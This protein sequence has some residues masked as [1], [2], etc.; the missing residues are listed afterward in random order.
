MLKRLAVLAAI[1]GLAAC[2]DSGGGGDK[3]AVAPTTNQTTD[4]IFPTVEPT[5]KAD[6]PAD[7]ILLSYA[8][9]N[10]DIVPVLIN[11]EEV[12]LADWPTVVRIQTGNAGCTATIVG[13]KVL[14]TAAH[15]GTNGATSAFT[16]DG[17]R[18]EG[19]FQRSSLYPNQ[20]HD[21]AVII[22]NTAVPKDK[23]KIYAS[24]GGT[25]VVGAKIWLLGYGCINAGGGGGNDGKLRA[26]FATITSFS[27]YDVVSSSGAALCFGDSGGP[28]M[29]D[30]NKDKPVVM[31]V[32]SKGDIRTTNYT[33]NL[34]KAESQTFLR[35]VATDSSLEI[36]G[37]NGT[38]ATCDT[39][40][41]PPPPPPPPECDTARKK[42]ILAG[43]AQCLNIGS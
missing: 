38:P 29:V 9:D 33:T 10:G 12:P 13:P 6:V 8:S 35:K 34:A 2:T 22:L 31:T 15:C 23:V 42:D 4:H 24:V 17:T 27:G 30:N 7:R 37:I 19:K 36:C 39:G 11:G 25:P 41:N 32:N 18:Y 16:L 5:A 3:K 26:G 1:A 14:V 40:D 43:F 28:G 21:V 20:D